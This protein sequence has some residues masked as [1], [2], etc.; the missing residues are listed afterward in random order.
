MP[1]GKERVE[2][3]V[4]TL[5]HAC[6]KECEFDCIFE[7]FCS[8]Q[9]AVN[10]CEFKEQRLAHLSTVLPPKVISIHCID[11]GKTGYGTIKSPEWG[12]G[13]AETEKEDTLIHWDDSPLWGREPCMQLIGNTVGTFSLYVSKA[14]M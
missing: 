9:I 6:V 14:D 2:V 10:Q 11:G 13:N 12:V 4:H 8:S 1:L 5:F 3:P 7:C